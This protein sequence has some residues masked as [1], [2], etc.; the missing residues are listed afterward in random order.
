MGVISWFIN[1]HSHH[2]W[3]Q[4]A[5]PLKKWA[6]DWWNHHAAGAEPGRQLSFFFDSFDKGLY[7]INQPTVMCIYIYIY[8]IRMYDSINQ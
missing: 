7:G 8:I 2:W 5:D 4:P 1:Q 3:P 6:Q